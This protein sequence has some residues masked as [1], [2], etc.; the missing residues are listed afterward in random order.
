VVIVSTKDRNKLLNADS[1]KDGLRRRIIL[2]SVDVTFCFG[3]TM[4]DVFVED[5]LDVSSL[6]LFFG[7][8]LFLAD[9]M[10]FHFVKNMLLTGRSDGF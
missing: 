10:R 4:V 5:R 8:N 1:R 3:P 7:I 9:Q 6:I 2:L